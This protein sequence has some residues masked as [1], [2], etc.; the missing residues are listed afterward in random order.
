MHTNY[1]QLHLA[2]EPPIKLDLP[3]PPNQKQEQTTKDTIQGKS[4]INLQK[5]PT[6]G[7]CA[8]DE[9]NLTLSV[10]CKV[11]IC[12]CWDAEDLAVAI[13]IDPIRDVG[14]RHYGV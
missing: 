11:V 14:S 6:K 9:L 2:A 7:Y 12:L 1:T 8:N 4:E 3:I 13:Q 10:V 5:S